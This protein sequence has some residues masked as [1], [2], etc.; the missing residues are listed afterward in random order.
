MRTLLPICLLCLPLLAAAA[1]AADFCRNGL[2]PREQAQLDLGVIQG[3]ANEP[4]HFY[5]D[6]D[7]CPAKGAACRRP[8]Y[9]VPGDAVV[10]GKRSADYAC[11]WYQGRKHE[12]V[13]WVPLKHVALRPAR[14]L[15]RAGDWTGLWGD[16]GSTIRIAP[17]GKGGELSIISKLRWEGG[18]GRANFGGMTGVLKLEG[19]EGS[20]AE[21]ECRVALSR[22]GDYL[23]ADDNG[24]C[25]GINVR[26][27]GMYRRRK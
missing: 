8:S 23:V 6:N 14:P 3:R 1:D 26:H 27:T 25:G 24:A 10:V 16:G 22:I 20:A 12:S 15:D 17:A 18:E 13:S 2:F 9:L 7:G 19:A 21:G 11:V 5:D 4:V